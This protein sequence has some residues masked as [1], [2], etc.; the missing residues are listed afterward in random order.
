MVKNLY[1]L[2]L[3]FIFCACKNE[4][5]QG[6]VEINPSISGQIIGHSDSFLL[7][8]GADTFEVKLDSVGNYSYEFLNQQLG[9]YSIIFGM[10][11]QLPIYINTNTQLRL[12][13]DLNKLKNVQPNPVQFSGNNIE[14]TEL[15]LELEFDKPN[16]KYSRVDY[17]DKYTPMLHDKSSEEFEAFLL[18]SLN[19]TAKTIEA[20]KAKYPDISSSLIETLKLNTLLSLNGKF[21][22][23]ESTHNYLTPNNLVTAPENF[24]DYFASKI[25]QNDLELY[26]TNQAYKSYLGEQYYAKMNEALKSYERETMPYFKAEVTYLNEADIPEI[27]KSNMYNG[28]TISYMRAKDSEIKEYLTTIISKYVTD[29]VSLQRFE[30]FKKKETGYVNGDL[31][32]NF[33]YP[34]IKEEQVSLSDFKGQVVYIDLWATWCGPCI[35]EMP[36]F[37]KLKEKY[38]GQNIAFLGVS[39]DENL[40]AWKKM[41]SENKWM[42]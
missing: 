33:T 39:F 41:V 29:V 40:A 27:I 42:E 24:K 10:E 15:L 3:V 14:E 34:N 5:K 7:S 21:K 32:P 4:T 25:P 13:L 36:N 9:L 37:K 38:K 19:K 6:E 11:K 35:K 31:A 8:N 17:K 18:E 23:Y 12:D 22:R 2:V 16:H 30:N 28:L 20:H 1:V 26:Q